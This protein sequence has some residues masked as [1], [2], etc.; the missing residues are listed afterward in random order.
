MGKKR[1]EML[2]NPFINFINCVASWDKI[3]TT[4]ADRRTEVS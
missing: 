2:N 3:K 4:V 1:P